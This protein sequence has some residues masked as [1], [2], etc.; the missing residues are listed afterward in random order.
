MLSVICFNLDQ[1]KISWSGN[2][3]RRKKK[4]IGRHATIPNIWTQLPPLEPWKLHK[5]PKSQMTK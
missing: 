3:F 2:G 5:T 4:K 1:S